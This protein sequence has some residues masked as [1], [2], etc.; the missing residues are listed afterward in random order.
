MGTLSTSQPTAAA[1]SKA[2][3]LQAD[4][5]PQHVEPPSRRPHPHAPAAAVLALRRLALRRRAQLRV[6]DRRRPLLE[7]PQRGEQR[8]ERLAAH[9]LGTRRRLGARAVAA[10]IWLGV[11]ALR[12]LAE[13]LCVVCVR[14][15]RRVKLQL[16]L[17][18]CK[19]A[20]SCCLP[21][22][23]ACKARASTACAGGSM[24][25]GSLPPPHPPH[26]YAALKQV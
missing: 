22:A 8:G 14:V 18:H 15:G 7:R 24:H 16:Q 2:A 21:A 6:A 19:A 12:Q 10:L 23:A 11:H 9:A 3:K 13:R 4:S 20:A 25:P 1:G 26:L 17:L 5:R